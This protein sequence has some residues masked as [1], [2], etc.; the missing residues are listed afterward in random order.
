ML[1]AFSLCTALL[2]CD[3]STQAQPHA[4]VYVPSNSK[5]VVRGYFPTSRQAVATVPSGAVVH[6]DT[7][8]HQGLGGNGLT[9]R[10]P[11]WPPSV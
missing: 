2:V 9:I 4:I 8:S 7:V 6:I 1:L 5:T 11:T 3:G 10:S